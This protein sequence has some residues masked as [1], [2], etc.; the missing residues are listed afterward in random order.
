MLASIK[1]L[2]DAIA[3]ALEGYS[4]KQKLDGND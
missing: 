4:L 2:K 1:I 3:K